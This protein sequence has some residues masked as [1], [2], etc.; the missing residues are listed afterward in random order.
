M[1]RICKEAGFFQKSWHEFARKLS[2]LKKPDTNLQG[3]WLFPK[4]LARTCKE[5]GFPA[6]IRGKQTV[7]SAT[8]QN[9]VLWKASC[10]PE[11][12]RLLH[13]RLQ[14]V[15]PV[16]DNGETRTLCRPG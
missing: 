9:L 16:R 12:R 8:H 2:A 13:A 7:R 3:S 5:A 6:R 11:G 15:E 1:T 4:N 14:L 10:G